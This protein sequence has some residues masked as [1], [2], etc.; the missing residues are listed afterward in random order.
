MPGRTRDPVSE[1]FD[2]GARVLLTRAYARPGQWAGTRVAAPSPRQVAYFASMGINVLGRD[3][4]GRDRWAAGFIRAVYYQ[5]KWFYSQGA[6]RT[7]KRMA[8]NDARAIRYELGRRM[9]VL[10]VIPAGRAVR[11]MVQPGGQAAMRAVKRLP[12]SRRIWDDTGEPAARWADPAL[13]D[14]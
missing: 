1:L 12:D 11:I 13:R 7:S 14:W 3:Q 10:G 2:R 4:W 9:P 8:A 5:H 6:L